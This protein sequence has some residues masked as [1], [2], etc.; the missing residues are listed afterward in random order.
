MISY[1][2]SDHCLHPVNLFKVGRLLSYASKLQL[3]I[4]KNTGHKEQLL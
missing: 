4:I 1:S 2:Y 3:Q